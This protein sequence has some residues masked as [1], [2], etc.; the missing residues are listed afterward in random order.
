MRRHNRL[1]GRHS[2]LASPQTGHGF[3][4][5]IEVQATLAVEVAGS[6]SGYTLLV[7]GEAEHRKWHGYRNVDSH[8][9]CLDVLLEAG[10]GAAAFGEYSDTVAV[11]VRIDELDG[12]VDCRDV[13]ADKDRAENLLCVAFHVWFNVSN[14][15]GAD[16]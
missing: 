13:D 2:I 6:A 3:R 16:L 4:L 9:A 12:L 1:F 8:L 15:S 7:S 10:G 14:D 11:F 5:R